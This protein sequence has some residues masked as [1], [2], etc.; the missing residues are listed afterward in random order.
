MIKKPNQ[1]GTPMVN[2]IGD[3]GQYCNLNNHAEEI[4]NKQS[5]P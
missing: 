3:P 4:A 5:I 2:R 1:L